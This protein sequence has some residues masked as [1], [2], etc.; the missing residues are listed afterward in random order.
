VP[1][2]LAAV[3]ALNMARVVSVLDEAAMRHG[4]DTTVDEIVFPALRV[5]GTFWASGTLDVVHERVLSSGVTRWVY[6]Q[7][8]QQVTHR[9]GRILI[10]AGPEDLHTVGLDCFELLLAHRGVDVCNLGA[11]VPTASLS[12]AASATNPRAVV[13]CSHNPTATSSA[14]ESV[15]AAVGA[16]HPTYYSGS[17]FQSQFVR[18][19]TP[20]TPLDGTLRESADLLTRRHTTARPSEQATTPGRPLDRVRAG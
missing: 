18:R 7:L 1:P 6:S 4:L 5:V 10:A 20:G 15:H 3:R 9:Q 2:I 17:T 13:L 19:H 16:G 12:V 14:V 11:R 8:E